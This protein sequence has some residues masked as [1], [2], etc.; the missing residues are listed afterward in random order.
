[1][2]PKI[3]GLHNYSDTNRNS[4]K[5]TSAVIKAIGGGGKLW[6][7]ETGGLYEFGKNFKASAK[8]QTKAT[9]NVFAIAKKY[10][11]IERVYFYNFYGPGADHPDDVFDA[12]LVSGTDDTVR[13]AYA[14]FK[15]KTR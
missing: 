11:R 8:R 3:W 4:M 7:T 2:Q 13:P 12:G 5:R 15:K 9:N 14:A 6:V 10:K 1:M